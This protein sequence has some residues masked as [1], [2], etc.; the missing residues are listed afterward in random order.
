MVLAVAVPTEAAELLAWPDATRTVFPEPTEADARTIH[1]CADLG[2]DTV[3]AQSCLLNATLGSDAAALQL[4]E[5]LLRTHGHLV[6]V[7]P[8]F[9]MDGGFRG[10]IR[11]EPI[12]PL[13]ALRVHLERVVGALNDI[14]MFLAAVEARAP[15]PM[16]YRWKPMPIRFFES[17]GRKTPSAY[18]DWEGVAY[19]VR[20]SLNTSVPRV[21][22]TL[23]HELFHDND[24]RHGSWS[25]RV[26][27]TGYARV[28][29]RCG[30]RTACL[31][32]YAPHTTIVRGGT[33]YAFQPG[34]GVGEYAAELAIRFHAETAQA[35]AGKK[36]TGPPFKCGPPQNALAWNALVEEFFGGLDLSP[37]CR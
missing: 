31:K 2:T 37:A 30:A 4:A 32:P 16:R 1:R 20:G 28:L 17:V 34:N 8:A 11:V 3:D 19:N 26:L 21:V 5:T 36:A 25:S 10:D 12:R 13:G 23:F 33:Y 27:D 9:V 7:T 6:G 15:Q 14:N 22:E 35:L 18:V 24:R 29:Q